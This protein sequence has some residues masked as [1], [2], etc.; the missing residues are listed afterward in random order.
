MA[1]MIAFCGIRCDR[2]DTFQA[3]QTNDDA[4]R[5]QIAERWSR[6]FKADFRPEQMNCAGCR[7]KN[8]PV[9]FYCSMCSVRKCASTRGVLTCAHCNDYG[10]ST[11]QQFWKM[12]PEN[13]RLLEEMRK[14]LQP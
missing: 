2:C 3:T 14:G 4:R 6:Q 1:E 5:R 8:G 11:L 7:S 12:S 9:F 10:C 13:K